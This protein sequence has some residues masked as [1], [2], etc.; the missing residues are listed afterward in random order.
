MDTIQD[1][2]GL[3]NI[4][5]LVDKYYLSSDFN[6]LADKTK[7]DNIGLISPID[8]PVNAEILMPYIFKSSIF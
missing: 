3:M 5:S 2:V 7:V 6:M 8:T 1:G 4:N